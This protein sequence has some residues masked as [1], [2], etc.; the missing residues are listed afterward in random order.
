MSV[1]E[2]ARLG[3]DFS[4]LIC[5]CVSPKRGH[6]NEPTGRTETESVSGTKQFENACGIDEPFQEALL[7]TYE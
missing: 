7:R 3:L 5:F 1:A 6:F 2:V 4:H